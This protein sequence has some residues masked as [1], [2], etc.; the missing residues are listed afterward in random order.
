MNLTTR[1]NLRRGAAACLAAGLLTLSGCGQEAPVTYLEEVLP[2]NDGA[3]ATL[4][5]CAGELL[6]EDSFRQALEDIVRKYQADWPQTQITLSGDTY[7]ERERSGGE[8]PDIFVTT[9]GQEDLLDF[10]PYLDAWDNQGSL[11]NA[12][13]LA[14][15]HRGG[16]GAYVVPIDTSQTLLY[17]REDWFTAFNQG[18][19][20]YGRAKIET[21]DQLA[22][23]AVKLE[24]QG[25]VALAIEPEELFNSILW[26]TLGVGRIADRA[27]GYYPPRTDQR[28]VFSTEQAQTAV[29]LLQKVWEVRVEGSDPVEAFVQGKTGMLIAGHEAA[30]TLAQKMPEGTWTAVGLPEGESKT[31]VVPC[32]WVGLGISA[33]TQEPEKAVHFLSYLTGADCN[34]HMAK[35]CGT[36]PIYT[37]AVYMEP[38][39]LEGPRGHELALQG[40]TVYRFASEPAALKEGYQQEARVAKEVDALLA[41]DIT[42]EEFLSRLDQYHLDIL[43]EYQADGTLLPWAEDKEDQESGEAEE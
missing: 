26:S 28:T 43:R 15:H 19:D 8:L 36:M 20:W 14:M 7:E 30:E 32:S 42:E 6:Q 27:A 25:G 33:Q 21:W 34:T 18:K 16:Q 9:T 3:S 2:Q 39:L 37:E 35:L 38:S 13:R 40:D 4:T 24:A 5:L 10:S 22:E 1:N 31:I 41:G 29:E 17:Y 11:S 12:A 23:S